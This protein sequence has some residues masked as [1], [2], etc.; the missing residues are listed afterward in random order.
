MIDI[1]T[2]RLHVVILAGAVGDFTCRQ[3]ATILSSPGFLPGDSSQRH[4]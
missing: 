2:L 1:K 3:S 4:A